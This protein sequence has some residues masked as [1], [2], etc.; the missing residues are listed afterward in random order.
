MTG[1]RRP[2]HTDSIAFSHPELIA[3]SQKDWKTYAAEPPAG[4]LRITNAKAV[5]L[6]T[7][8]LTGLAKKLPGNFLHAGGDEV[9]RR[10][11]EDDA[12]TQ[13]ALNAS[14]ES[15]EEAVAGFANKTTFT[16]L[17][18]GKT[19]IVWEEYV[20]HGSTASLDSQVVVTAWRG[21]E[22]L[23][24]IL[25]TGHRVI[26][27][28]YEYFYLDCGMGGWVR[29]SV[30]TSFLNDAG[31]TG[32]LGRLLVSIQFLVENL[33]VRSRRKRPSNTEI[34]DTRRYVPSYS[35]Q[36]RVAR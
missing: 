15:L 19:P 36:R 24:K 11:Y 26:Q 20:T 3:C 17:Q 13:S 23:S 4:Q 29:S 10:C 2:A 31:L 6:V 18:A 5:K 16:V 7:S 12:E 25:E 34:A 30:C 21:S 28:S 27:V 35:C 22:T 33:L 8:I 9:N 32:R 1:F 14:G